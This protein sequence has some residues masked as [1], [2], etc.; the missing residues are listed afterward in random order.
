MKT[1]NRRKKAIRYVD[2]STVQDAGCS[3]GVDG[4]QD[5]DVDGC[6]LYDENAY[7]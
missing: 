1:T 6:R 5:V 4:D 7:A 3:E 2:V